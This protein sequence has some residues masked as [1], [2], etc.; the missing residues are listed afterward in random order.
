[1]MRQIEFAFK[2]DSRIGSD[3]RNN[4]ERVMTF[5]YG[6]DGRYI[7]MANNTRFLVEREGDG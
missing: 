1:M 4:F 3:Y 2:A 7:V 6:L 5:G